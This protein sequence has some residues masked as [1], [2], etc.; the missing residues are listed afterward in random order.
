MARAVLPLTGIVEKT[1]FELRALLLFSSV[2]PACNLGGQLDDII[3]DAGIEAD[4]SYEMSLER[5]DPMTGE[6]ETLEPPPTE[7]GVPFAVAS[8]GR[9][10]V[11]GGYDERLNYQSEVD[12][13]DPATG[14][15][16]EG[17]RWTNSR[18]APMVEVNGLVCALGGFRTID[19]ETEDVE[20]Y[21]VLADEWTERAPLPSTSLDSYWPVVH[22]GKIYVLGGAR[23][24]QN[25]WLEPLD[26]AYVYDPA[27][28]TWSELTSLPDPR[29]GASAH[30]IGDRIYVVGGFSERT[31]GD[32]AD[33]GSMFIYEP[34][35][36][37]WSTGANL[38]S[39]RTLYGADAVNGEIAV[40]L[41][42]TTG[43][44]L[45]RYSDAD[46]A[47]RA[48]TEPALA[49]D[50]GVYTRVVHGDSLYIL[51]LADRAGTYGTGATGMLH[52]YS[53][54]DD[55]WTLAGQRDPDNRDAYFVGNSLDD[56][57]YFVG[58]FTTVGLRN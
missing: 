22:D 16:S 35:T 10:V 40:Y 26:G 42:V 23:L 2:L 43:P 54:P 24:S 5:F 56:G 21:D 19:A 47:W 52:R 48:G 31:L 17:A 6:F 25:D 53:M 33:D 12:V 46:G 50:P 36:D 44:L 29:G 41:G 34:S 39:F 3:A 27:L 4:V 30:V 14:V 55:E 51:V 58:S 1:R 49:L 18:I 8:E 20:C 45:E 57:I 38:A 9:V 32:D 37:S 28:D 11:L 13:Y 15:W 7:R